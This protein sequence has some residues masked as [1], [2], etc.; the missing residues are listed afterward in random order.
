[1]SFLI[2]VLLYKYTKNYKMDCFLYQ[3]VASVSMYVS[4]V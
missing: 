3:Y 4:A 2:K 1:M